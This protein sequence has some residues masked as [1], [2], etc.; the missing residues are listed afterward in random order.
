VVARRAEEGTPW[1]ARALFAVDLDHP[2]YLRCI[3]SEFLANPA[4][5]SEVHVP[6]ETLRH[7]EVADGDRV[8]MLPLDRGPSAA[9][10]RSDG[11]GS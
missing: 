8:A 5:P 9:P 1:T 3:P 10:G 7:L 2:P 11:P 6:A 4:E